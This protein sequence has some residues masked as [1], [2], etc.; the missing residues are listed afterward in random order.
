MAGTIQP[1]L[2]AG[3]V[4]FC[5]RALRDEGTSHHYDATAARYAE[6]TAVFTQQLIQKWPHPHHVGASWTTDAPYR[7]TR[8]EVDA[9]AAEGILTVEMEA[10]A[11]FTVGNYLGVETA[12]ILVI[13]DHVT[14]TGWT[15]DFDHKLVDKR[16]RQVIDFLCTDGNK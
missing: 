15:F 3:D 1:H 7:E 13:G 14:P 10:A 4:M 12:A 5:Q 16:L 2:Q 11:L 8:P 6:A 9:Y